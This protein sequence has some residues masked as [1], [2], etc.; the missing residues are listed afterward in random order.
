M[1]K[2]EIPTRAKAYEATGS[3]GFSGLGGFLVY[4]QS[5]SRVP[6]VGNCLFLRAREWGIELLR[7]I[8]IRSTN[9]AFC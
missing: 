2:V 8:G 3:L 9:V 5:M 1:G 4:F 6:G 7:E